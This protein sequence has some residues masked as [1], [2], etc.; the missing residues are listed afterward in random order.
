MHRLDK[1]MIC[2][3]LEILFGDFGLKLG[4]FMSV[5][6]RFGCCVDFVLLKLINLF[7]LRDLYC[8]IHGERISN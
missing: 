3:V 8:K 5:L 2:Y 4:F 7:E 1:I 6:S